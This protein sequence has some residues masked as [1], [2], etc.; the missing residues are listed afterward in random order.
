MKSLKTFDIL[1]RERE[2]EQYLVKISSSFGAENE[3]NAEEK[4]TDNDNLIK[5]NKLKNEYK[6]KK[7]VDYS[8]KRVCLLVV[9]TKSNKKQ[10]QKEKR[11]DKI[12]LQEKETATKDERGKEN[13]GENKDK[14]A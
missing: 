12:Y 10:L 2:R 8:K 11:Y 9:K 1:E 7:K 4:Y 5:T 3:K 6:Y 13:M 14:Y